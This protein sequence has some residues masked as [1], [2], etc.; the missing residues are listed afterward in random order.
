MLSQL[1]L[2]EDPFGGVLLRRGQVVNCRIVATHPFGVYLSMEK[3]NINGLLHISQVSNVNVTLEEFYG[4]ITKEMS[5]RVMILDLY[6]DLGTVS[7]CTK[8]FESYPGELLREGAFDKVAHR[9]SK[10][11]Y[12]ETHENVTNQAVVN[13]SSNN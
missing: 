9:F 2:C 12:I 4:L 5:M 8:V 3:E 11:E 10:V 6:P 13:N 7:F 1:R